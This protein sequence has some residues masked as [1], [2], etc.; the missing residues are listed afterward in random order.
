M[1]D[2]DTTAPPEGRAGGKGSRSVLRWV[3]IGLV[4]ALVLGVGGP[5]VYIHF[6]TED[7]P[8]PLTVSGATGGGGAGASNGSIEGTWK[9]G[10]GSQAGYRAKE[11]LLGQ[12]AEAVG[13]TTSVSGEV[14]IAGTK[15]TAAKVTVDLTTVKS[16]KSQRDGQFQGRIMRTSQFPTATFSLTS[17]IDLGSIPGDGATGTYKATGDLTLHGTTKSVTLD[18]VA[19][20]GATIEVS[21]ST[22]ITFADYGIDNPSGGPAQVGDTGTME[23]LVVLSR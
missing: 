7:A 16:D 3:V 13:R 4:A 5:F 1:S 15:V 6:F 22:V 12:S 17:P 18:L 9:V 14:T 11:I 23:F 10:S 20:R 19:K 2:R 21:G 8:P